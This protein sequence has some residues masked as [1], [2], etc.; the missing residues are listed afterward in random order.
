MS[1]N[2]DIQNEQLQVQNLSV[3][4]GNTLNL[5]L[6]LNSI[7]VL[8]LVGAVHDLISEALGDGLKVAERGV[9][10]TLSHEVDSDV[11]TAEG[12]DIT[13][14]AT[15]DTTVTDAG[16]VLTG[17]TLG[18]GISE[19]LER[20]LL[21]DKSDDLESLLDDLDSEE[22][23]AGVAAVHHERVNKALDDGASGLLESLLGITTSSV[24][25]EDRAL[26]DS[27]VINESEVGDLD[28]GGRELV[29]ESDLVSE[30]S[31]IPQT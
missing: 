31:H 7:R 29:K 2:I 17:T 5:V 1:T 27:D 16:R 12:R 28:I 9:T 13:S 26:L 25:D 14:L 10:S 23:L 22:L 8:V 21:G 4:L 11:D 20:V 24:G 19:D 3:G 30:G 6:L 15:D 18:D